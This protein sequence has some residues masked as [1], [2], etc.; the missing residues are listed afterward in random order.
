MKRLLFLAGMI[1]SASPAAF[2]Q[3]D[4]TFLTTEWDSNYYD[5]YATHWSIRTYAV[6]KDQKFSLLDKNSN[7]KLFFIPNSKASVGFGVAYGNY[8]LDLGFS[9]SNNKED[10]TNVSES[11]DFIGGLYSGQHA[12]DVNF[13]RYAGFFTS[14]NETPS[15]QEDSIFRS[16]IRTFTF[17]VNYNYNF[18]YGRYSLNAP[19]IGTERQKKSAGTPLAGAFFYYFDLRANTDIVP[20]DADSSFN[21]YA[22]FAESNLLSTGLMA[23]YAYTLVLPLDFFITASIVP[24]ISF[25]LGDAKSE[26]YY[27]IG[28]P[29]TVSG[30]L[31]F[32]TSM[33]YNGEKVYAL[34]SYYN[35]SNLVY[36]GNDNRFKYDLSKF[37]ILAGFRFQ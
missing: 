10:T 25:N 8:A 29:F 24:G 21:E 5:R 22:H 4:L 16:D 32:R 36:L 15:D 11:F 6:S 34:I 13:Q 14:D 20:G 31:V 17:G 2:A 28:R 35:D 12:F 19:F 1:L 3:F 9:V 33:G 7:S 23:G 18:N 26:K 37:K 27:D 30:K